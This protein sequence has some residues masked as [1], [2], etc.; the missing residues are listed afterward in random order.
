MISPPGVI[1]EVGVFS[2]VLVWLTKFWIAPGPLPLEACEKIPGAAVWIVRFA[3]ALALPLTVTTTGA[4][5]AV[6]AQ[7]TW[8]L[9]CPP[10]TKYNAA[11]RPW[12]VTDV[13]FRLKGKG[14]LEAA[15]TDV[16]K[17]VPK[18]EMMEPGATPPPGASGRR[19]L[20]PFKI[21][22]APIAGW[23]ETSAD[24]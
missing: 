20:A 16:A 15:L 6:V 10:E 12:M 17:F 24:R 3:A 13:P 23:A 19:K 1:D 22:P 2:G 14:T 5:P 11:G 4:V 21:P 18:I 9:I 7:G 8:A